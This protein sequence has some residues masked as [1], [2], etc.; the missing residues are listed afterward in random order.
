VDLRRIAKR[1]LPPIAVDIARNIR[2]EKAFQQYLHGQRIPWSRG[3]WVY[4]ERTIT[5]ALRDE[6]L[7]YRFRQGEPLPHGYGIG[8]DERCIEYPWLLA[9]LHDRPETLLDAGSTL[10]FDFILDHPVL[11]PKQIHILT[12]APE[13]DCFW[14]KS[15]SYLFHDLRDIPIRDAYYDSIACLSTLE[16]IGCNNTPITQI[17]IHRE[18]DTESLVYAMQEFRRVLKPG[19]SLFLTVPFGVYQHM[20]VQQQFDRDMLS[21]AVGAFGDAEKVSE[22]FYRY[23]PEGWSLADVADC[24][25][26]EYVESSL[27]H[28]AYKQESGSPP[29]EPDMAAAARAVA[30]VKI[31][32]DQPL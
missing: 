11:K 13:W 14:Q 29:L 24:A 6:N 20:G 21:R 5:K 4:W 1:F 3:Y 2:A 7:L 22:N 15:I 9:H 18:H 23:T 19:G 27:W 25:Q 12:L 26:C 31:V 30:C 8:I 17:D 10:N 32:K 28:W 16:H